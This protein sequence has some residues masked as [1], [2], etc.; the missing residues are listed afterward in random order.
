MDPRVKLFDAQNRLAYDECY[1]LGQDRF[2]RSGFEYA[3]TNHREGDKRRDLLNFSSDQHNLRFQDGIGVPAPDLIDQ[4]SQ[5]RNDF[6][7]TPKG[8]THLPSR[9]FLAVPDMSHGEP[10]PDDETQLWHVDHSTATRQISEK[11]LARFEPLIGSIKTTIQDPS[12]IVPSGWIHG[13]EDTRARLRD[14]H[15]LESVIQRFK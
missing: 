9:P 1:E 5:I 10:R 6:G 15:V 4:S 8:R 14:P 7:W 3:V 2:N 11:D 12:H 13:G